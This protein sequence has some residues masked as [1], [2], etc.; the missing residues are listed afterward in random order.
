MQ[1][2]QQC[3]TKQQTAPEITSRSCR[4]CLVRVADTETLHV[5]T[6]SPLTV[7]KMTTSVTLRFPSLT[8]PLRECFQTVTN[9]SYSSILYLTTILLPPQYPQY[10]YP[11]L[12]EGDSGLSGNEGCSLD[13]TVT[14]AVYTSLITFD[15]CAY[16]GWVVVLRIYFWKNFFYHCC[17]CNPYISG[18]ET[19]RSRTR[20]SL[21]QQVRFL[22]EYLFL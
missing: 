18:M 4:P 14:E 1:Y 11:R 22:K 10:L 16:V 5:M 9:A 17:Y 12:F 20:M 3:T 21:L 2:W 13:S 7:R 6:G 8:A 15:T 19:S